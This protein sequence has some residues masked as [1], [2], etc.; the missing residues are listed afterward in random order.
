LYLPEL[1]PGEDLYVR[2]DLLAGARLAGAQLDVA[3][4]ELVPAVHLALVRED[5][6]AAAAWRVDRHRL[7]EALLNVRRPDAF[8]VLTLHLRSSRSLKLSALSPNGHLYLLFFNNHKNARKQFM[9]SP[10]FIRIELITKM[11]ECPAS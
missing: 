4:N 5:D 2:A 8:R 11:T 1:P 9:I 10:S 7:L 6:L 3:R